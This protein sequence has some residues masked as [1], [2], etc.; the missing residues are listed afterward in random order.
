MMKDVDKSIETVVCG[1][2]TIGLPTYMEWDRQVLEHI[3]DF[4]DYISLHRYV[5]NR[6]NDTPDYLAVTN[7]IDRQIEEMDATCRYVQ[8]RRRSKKRPYLCFD[9]W[10]VW[11]KNRQMD[12]EGKL[13][14]HLI[15]EVY[16]L[17]DALVVAGFLNSFIRH[18][19]VLKI[20]N[21]AQIANVIAP[22]LTRGD[23]L[24]I[25]SIFYPFEMFAKRRDGVALRA[26]VQGP[27]YEGK[28]NGRVP[29]LDVSAILGAVAGE[30]H[31]FASNRS[32][33]SAAPV[34]VSLADRSIA[35]LV[36]AELLTGPNAQAAN[37]YEQPDVVCARPFADVRI[38]DGKASFELPPLSVAALTLRL[39]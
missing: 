13:A 27:E 8:A 39:A 11:Y 24:L 7:S 19:D 6:D 22:I 20:A 9:E 23:D 5:G 1:S 10:N 17:E 33:D 25:Q 26:L 36:S 18:A 15:E 14:P 30:V 21:I 38:A 37:S 16:N 28:S 34:Q 3:G 35:G 2:C 31:V 32:M 29:Y 12:G 4:A